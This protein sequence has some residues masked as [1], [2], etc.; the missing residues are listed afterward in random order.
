MIRLPRAI[1]FDCDGVLVD[2]EPLANQMLSELITS[3]GVPMSPLDCR[4]AFTGL[5][6]RG[7]ARR[8]IELHNLDLSKPLVNVASA[9]FMTALKKNGLTP[10]QGVAETLRRL[11][12]LNI[13]IAAASNSPLDEL[14]F[15]LDL[16]GIIA[17]FA[18]HHYSGDAL[19]RPK[20]DPAVY[21]H[22]ALHLGVA[23][24]D[25]IVI[26][27]S[28]LGVRAGVA[29]GMTVWGFTGTHPDPSHSRVLLH[30]GAHRCI[31]RIDAIAAELA[32]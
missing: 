1:L 12:E 24:S 19:G 29:A 31:E 16:A 21:L 30:A 6:P 27:D 2:T 22:A 20:P 4:A 8:L 28:P 17:Y 9:H 14:V 11:Q 3:H 15:K 13:A 32:P 18:P 25:C 23:P 7:V 26:E 10:L 5:N